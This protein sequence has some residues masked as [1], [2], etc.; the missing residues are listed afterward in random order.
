MQ[1][2]EHSG[3]RPSLEDVARAAGVSQATASRVIS[4]AEYPVS[5]PVR[6]RVLTAA[7]RLGYVPDPLAQAM[8]TGTSRM[9]GVIVG[10]ATDPYFAEV[11][12]GIEEYARRAGYLTILCSADREASIETAYVRLLRG[13]RAAG[14]VL[15]G[16][17]FEPSPDSADL[18]AELIDGRAAGM[19]IIALTDRRSLTGFPLI[20][21]DDTAMLHD[22]VGHLIRNGHRRLAFVGPDAGFSTS[23]RRLDGFLA[24]ARAGRLPEPVVVRT[25]FD[26]DAGRRAALQLLHEGLPDAVVGWSDETSLGV[27]AALTEAGLRIPEDIAVAG[28]DG[29]REAEL[30]GL[31]TV[32]VPMYELG[33]TAAARILNRT[34]PEPTRTMLPHRLAARRTTGLHRSFTGGTGGAR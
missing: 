29:T 6:R 7:E 30:V 16:G 28:V 33:A 27:V 4:G 5:E 15:V 23:D 1:P 19:Q 32:T 13:H 3:R 24:A 31:T 26:F 34:G 20:T 14:I 8:A 12:R 10:A 2:V 17:A 21:V 25:G 22:L 11:M 18:T 9:I